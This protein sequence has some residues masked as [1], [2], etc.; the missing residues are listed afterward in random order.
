MSSRSGSSSP[1]WSP[2]RS[3]WPRPPTWSAHTSDWRRGLSEPVS[4]AQGFYGLLAA[5]IGLAFAVTLANVSVIS[6]LVAASVIGGFGTPIGL[7]ILVL[8]AH[9][10]RVMGDQPISGRLA[11]AGWSVAVIVGSLG[12]LFVIGAVLGKF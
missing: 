2:S 5:S 9:D 12:L 10:D 7:V 6:M 1:L 11:V 3:S 8:L 4:H